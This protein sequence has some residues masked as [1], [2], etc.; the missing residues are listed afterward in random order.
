M[1]FIIKQAIQNQFTRCAD[2]L[3]KFDEPEI[4][5]IYNYIA[6]ANQMGNHYPISDT[7]DRVCIFKYLSD[8]K[9]NKNEAEEYVVFD[10]FSHIE[11]VM[12]GIT[13]HALELNKNN[14]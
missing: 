7:P 13:L 6:I 3:E 10:R 5:A 11:A 2:M 12:T 14:E 4:K 1:A 8:L 9:N